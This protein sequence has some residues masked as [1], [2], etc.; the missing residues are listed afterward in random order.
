MDSNTIWQHIDSQRSALAD[1]LTGL[2]QEQW[3]A[4]SL[5]EAWTV[6][7][8]AAHVAWEDVRL[9]QVPVPLIRARFDSNVMIRDTALRSRLSH[10]EIVAKIRS[11]EGR[12]VRPPFVSDMEPLTDV[13]VHTQDICIPLGLDHEPPQDA[14]MA[15][16][17]RMVALNEGRLR[18]RPPLRNTRLVATDAEWEHG[19]GDRVLRGSLKH[20]LLAVAGRRVAHAHIT[21]DLAALD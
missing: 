16:I 4:P 18:L 5:C 20:L 3:A 2:S 12:R 15:S 1:I 11:F 17:V 6:R 19:D 8:V 21:G 7:D 14:L 9:H 10:A 13:M